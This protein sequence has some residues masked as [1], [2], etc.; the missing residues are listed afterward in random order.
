VT[1]TTVLPP[2]AAAY[3]AAV[4]EA[5]DDLPAAERDDLLAEVETSL[6][7]RSA[8]GGSISANLGPPQ[9]FAAELRTAAGLDPAPLAA[10]GVQRR[11]WVDTVRR[12]SAALRK[13]AS[14][15][16]PIWWVVRGYVVVAVAALLADAHWSGRPAAVPHVPSAGAGLGFIAAAIILSVAAGVLTRRRRLRVAAAAA[17]VVLAAALVPVLVHLARL[18][19][20]PQSS[21]VETT[22]PTGL[23]YNGQPVDNVYPYSRSGRLLHD[24]LLFD[25]AGRPLDVVTSDHLRRVLRT[26]R[27][28]PIFNA[29]PIRYFEP[30]TRR[31]ARPNAAPPVTVPTVT[32]PP[33]KGANAGR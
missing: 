6:L 32:T 26:R 19:S 30:G 4:R 23:V 17:N 31:V 12:R 14:E 3:L 11:D 25:G 2:D 20:V 27:G 29:F 7:E 10:T 18:P 5:L 8:E 9:E 33:L 1:A 16:A 22:L 21:F 28:R 15:L 24:V 13:L